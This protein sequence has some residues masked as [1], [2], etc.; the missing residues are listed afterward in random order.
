MIPGR[1]FAGVRANLMSGVASRLYGWVFRL[2]I[3]LVPRVDELDR[4]L[5]MLEGDGDERVL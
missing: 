1:S 3:A 5:D 2:L 4:M